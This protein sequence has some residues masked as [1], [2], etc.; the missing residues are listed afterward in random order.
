MALPQDFNEEYNIGFGYPRSD[1]CDLL[2]LAGDNAKTE[3]R[4]SEVQ[5]EL[6]LR[7]MLA[8][9]HRSKTDPSTTVITFDLQQNLP[10]PTLTHG[11]YLTSG[12][13]WHSLG[14]RSEN[15]SIY[16]YNHHHY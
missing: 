7:A 11:F 16:I 1:T 4:R 15:S 9:S 3:E 2:I 13:A 5:T 6:L 10:V 8:D 12:N 14:E